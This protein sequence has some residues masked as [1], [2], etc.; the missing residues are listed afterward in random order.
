[1]R[2]FLMLIAV[3]SMLAACTQRPAPGYSV[4]YYSS[5]T[6]P[7]QERVAAAAPSKSVDTWVSCV[8]AVL[9]GID[10]E[11]HP[12]NR[13]ATVVANA[14]KEYA[15]DGDGMDVA[16]IARAIEN[17][18]AKQSA[19]PST[20]LT[21]A[22]KEAIDRWGRCALDTIT[23]AQKQKMDDAETINWAKAACRRFWTGSPGYDEP[24][25][26][27]MLKRAKDE[28]PG[29][30]ITPGPQLPPADKRA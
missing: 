8:A 4:Q 16:I 28:E 9:R 29:F 18:K 14:C 27:K 7:S 10:W 26:A 22:D 30:T 24:L 2:K 25:Y 3:G 13:V 21:I 1:M 19:R 17:R 11:S 15:V 6:T 23:E 5:T 12:V 20:D